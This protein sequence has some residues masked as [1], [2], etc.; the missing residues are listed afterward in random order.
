MINRPGDARLT[1]HGWFGEPR[2][3]SL[4]PRA[5]DYDDANRLVSVTDWD[6]NETT[7]AY[8]DAGRMTTVTFPSSVDTR[9]LGSTMVTVDSEGDMANAYTYDV[10][11]EPRSA[12]GAQDNEYQFT[13]QQV[14]GSTELQ[15][16]RAR[17]YD[18]EA[19]VLLLAAGG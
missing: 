4:A 18:M 10:Y 19:G 17:Y 1:L 7:F 16:L 5:Y 3:A 15:Y 2:R 14:D 12:T 11:G 8:D 6:L 9:A 13:G